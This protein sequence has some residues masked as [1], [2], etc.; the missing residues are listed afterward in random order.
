MY[1]SDPRASTW[2]DWDCPHYF[3]RLSRLTASVSL[4]GDGNVCILWHVQLIPIPV[5]LASV[6]S[7][8]TTLSKRLCVAGPT[9]SPTTVPTPHGII[10]SLAPTESPT[11][12][13]DAP[14][15]L[16]STTGPTIGNIARRTSIFRFHGGC[17]FASERDFSNNSDV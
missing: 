10:F 13:S 6:C 16:L 7:G 12:Q 11:Y 15:M 9:T 14:T 17:C 5:G 1:L 3:T 4:R 8:R 2:R